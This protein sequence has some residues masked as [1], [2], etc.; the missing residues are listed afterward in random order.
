MEFSSLAKSMLSIPQLNAYEKKSI[1]KVL[2]CQLLEV[3]KKKKNDNIELDTYHIILDNSVLYPE[4]GGQPYDLGFVNGM[5]VLR[6]DKEE[7]VSNNI[8]VTLPTSI[9]V[10]TDVICEIDWKRRYDH[11]QQHT[12][13]HLFSAIASK[14]LNAETV[15]WSKL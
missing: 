13:Q 6:V 2:S 4:G 1:N 12:A 11:M 9:E 14:S 3:E 15:G 8:R 7:G 10:G 5:E